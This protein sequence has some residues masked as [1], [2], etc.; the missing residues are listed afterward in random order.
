MK[1]NILNYSNPD[2][3]KFSR[4][5]RDFIANFCHSFSK[6]ISSSTTQNFI[7]KTRIPNE[8]ELYGVF[9]KSLYDFQSNDSIHVATEVQIKRKS[10]DYAS[11][12]GR[13]DL[14]VSFRKVTFLLE[15]KVC[16]I[17]LG[18]LSKEDKEL[19][20]RALKSW[21]GACN[22]LKE[23][24]ATSLGDILDAERVI[25]MP[26]V[27][28]LYFS[29][30]DR[31]NQD[32]AADIILKTE[33]LIDNLDSHYSPEVYFSY[34]SAFDDRIETHKRKSSSLIGGEKLNLYG[35]SFLSTI[36]E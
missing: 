23:L 17:P 16:R 8:R 19:S 30:V 4:I 9:V 21:Q 20:A 15:L 36:V 3:M 28:F 33:Q 2:S 14:V 18:E 5:T 11:S 35:F 22:Q 26:V 25:K 32:P 29:V 24:D 13:V 27:L 1:E 31:I 12:T 34:A 10:E 6:N 7:A